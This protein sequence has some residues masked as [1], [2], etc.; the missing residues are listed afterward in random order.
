MVEL[1]GFTLVLLFTTLFFFFFFNN[2]YSLQLSLKIVKTYLWEI[3][4]LYKNTLCLYLRYA[5]I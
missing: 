4:F 2:L 5:P 1:V 3:G